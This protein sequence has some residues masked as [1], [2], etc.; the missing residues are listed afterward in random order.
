MVIDGGGISVREARTEAEE[1]AKL[2]MKKND[3]DEIKK[4]MEHARHEMDKARDKLKNINMGKIM[5]EV[6]D[7]FNKAKLDLKELKAMFTKMESDGLIHSKEG[8]KVEYKNRDL[9]ING[10]KQKQPV[11]DKYRKYFK[12]DHFEIEIDKE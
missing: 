8:F 9:Y 3:H 6:K 5:N 10:E 7:G 12:E 11:I 1:K 4:E 2:E